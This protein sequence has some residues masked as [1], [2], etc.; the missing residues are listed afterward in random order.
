MNNPEVSVSRT[1]KA[2]H[3]ATSYISSHYLDLRHKTLL[4]LD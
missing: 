3:H 2:A 1:M 4:Y